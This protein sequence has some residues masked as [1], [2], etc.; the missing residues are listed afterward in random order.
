[1]VKKAYLRSLIRLFANHIVRFLSIS[2]IFVVTIGFLS[3]I[4]DSCD[5][6]YKTENNIYQKNN[7][8]DFI[9]MGT[10]ENPLTLMSTMMSAYSELSK[11]KDVYGIDEISTVFSIDSEDDSGS[12]YAVRH[13]YFD[14]K[15]QS[16]DKFELVKGRLPEN[17]QEAVVEHPTREIKEIEIGSKFIDPI[18]NKTCEVVGVIEN[19]SI[20][21]TSNEKSFVKVDSK[22]DEFMNL[23]AIYY[24]NNSFITNLTFNQIHVTLKDRSTQI[25]TSQ[26]QKKVDKFRDSISKLKFSNNL[27]VLSLYENYSFRLLDGFGD[28][29]NGVAKIFMIIFVAVLLLVV[30]STTSRLIDEE[31]S[32][33]ATLKTL[34][35]SSIMI[36]LRFVLFIIAASILGIL[37]AVGPSILVNYLVVNAINMQ[38]VVHESLLSILGNNFIILSIVSF[39]STFLLSIFSCRYVM[40]K[41]PA[42]LLV[43][44]T[45][46]FGKKI[47]LEKINFIWKKLPFKFKSTFRNIFLFKSKLIMTV[48][49]II[50]SSAMVFASFALLSNSFNLKG[51]SLT[52]I[53]ITVLIFSAILSA[54]IVYNI[55]NI[56]IS[57]RKREIAT[58]MVL[59]YKDSETCGY[60]FREISITVIISALIGL[61]IAVLIADFI[62]HY[63][64][65]GSLQV[66]EWWWY[67]LTPICTI[68]F[69]CIAMLLLKRKITK[70]DMNE[71]LKILE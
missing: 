1:M 71:S 17:D 25:L 70:T 3:G 42:E 53:S 65:F 56:N 39:V 51:N 35:Y 34:G 50:L 57:E 8:H 7:V 37:I 28:K 21:A 32:S 46:K 27:Q 44:K 14:I 62:L 67:V 13:S 15:N 40:K 16:I 33:V 55:A 41:K 5:S 58:L 2:A 24:L 26:Y 9:V 18:R 52:A 68:I 31:R 45:P 63:A 19:P 11:N 64:E 59:G 30:Y 69:S 4:G 36:S 47:L 49:S 6:I 22:S 20:F 54:L 61:P 10:S 38:V 12:G 48:L 23:N 60:I 66:V 43:A 29:T